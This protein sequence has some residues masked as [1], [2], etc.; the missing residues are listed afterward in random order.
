MLAPS[1]LGSNAF[2][3][4]LAGNPVPGMLSILVAYLLDLIVVGIHTR[5]GK[6]TGGQLGSPVPLCLWEG[7][8]Q[9]AVVGCQ[10]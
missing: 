10:V 6:G 5:I 1:A 7:G 3:S 4:G 9:N 8:C 2:S